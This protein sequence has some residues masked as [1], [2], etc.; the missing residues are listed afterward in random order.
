MHQGSDVNIDKTPIAPVGLR[1][2][3]VVGAL[4]ALALMPVLSACGS[5]PAPP[6]QKD[7]GPA[8]D[9]ASVAPLPRRVELQGVYGAD[10]LQGR[11]VTYRLDY[12]DPYRRQAYRDTR[13]AAPLPVLMNGRMRQL[14][15]RVPVNPAADAA[16]PAVVTIELQECLQAFSSAG[17]SEVVVRMSAIT[18]EGARRAFDR[19]VSAGSDADGAVR[20]TS[21]AIDALALEILNWAASTPPVPMAKR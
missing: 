9:S 13:W 11:D 4:A 17:K 1:R 10:T 5:R 15:A 14:I 19:S 21:Q 3:D 6:Q 7:L 2:R 18:E 12:A 20:A 8:P 16:Q